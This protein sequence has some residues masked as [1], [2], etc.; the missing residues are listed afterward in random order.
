MPAAPA[1]VY[2]RLVRAGFRQRSAYRAAMVAGVVAYLRTGTLE[3]FHLRPLSLLGQLVT[4]E[5]TLRNIG[6]LGVA[7]A[8]LGYGLATNPVA[9]SPATVLL[10]VLS[11]A[12]GA[13]I[14]SGVFVWAAALQFFLIDG[15]EGVNAFT[16][17]GRYASQQPTSILPAPL[18]VLFVAVVPVAFTG[19][20]PTLALLG[21]TAPPQLPWLNPALAWA[22]PLVAGGVWLVA[23][24]LWRLG[25]RHYQG[26]GG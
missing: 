15:R 25:V 1:A 26:G 14:F 18:L 20:L 12:S 17:G 11:V 7:C 19:Y 5:V 3:T 24:G 13:A 21:R 6:W 9:W 22:A 2:L 16:Y 8:A 4:A 23:L 10:I